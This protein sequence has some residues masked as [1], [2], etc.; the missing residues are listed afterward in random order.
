MYKN[1]R[2]VTQDKAQAL[3][4]YTKAADQGCAEAQYNL[5][6]MYKNGRGVKQD[7]VKALAWYTKAA[8][9]GC[10]EA[11]FDLGIMYKNGE[12][13]IKN[14]PEALAWYTKAAEQG[15]AKAQ[16][17]L[18]TLYCEGNGCVSRDASK[19][20][21]WYC[22]YVKVN[23]GE[24]PSPSKLLQCLLVNKI[25]NVANAEILA[26]VTEGLVKSIYIHLGGNKVRAN[27]IFKDD[28]TFETAVGIL[29]E[30][31]Q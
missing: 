8:N 27:Q 18:C 23:K 2:G 30:R 19:A 5:G 26:T 11:Q 6:S 1:G 28:P 29:E 14:H 15:H 22:E 4:W 17:M 31:Y 13:V 25:I 10:A 24:E 20:V 3:E 9:Q 12:G 21:G 16:F 7:N